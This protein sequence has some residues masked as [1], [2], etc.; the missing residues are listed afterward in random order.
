MREPGE[1]RLT[2]YKA[3]LSRKEQCLRGLLTTGRTKSLEWTRQGGTRVRAW[4]RAGSVRVR[5]WGNTGRAATR[6][7]VQRGLAFLRRHPAGLKA[8]RIAWMSAAGLLVLAVVC[9]ALWKIPQWQVADP[10]LTVKD[11][12]ELQDKARGTLAQIIG[13]MVILVGLY[14]TGRSAAAAWRNVQVTQE[15]QITERFT[16]A[17]EQLGNDKL[18]IRLGGIYALERIARD[19]PT[20]HWPIM[21]V[22]TAYVRE[23]APWKD[24][25]QSE[26][27]PAADIQAIL[28]VL[29]RR[30]YGQDE[31]Q[32]L[33][34]QDTD[35]RNVNL[36]GAHLEGAILMRAHL[37]D[38]DLWGAHLQG[39]NLLGAH[40]KKANLMDAHLTRAVLVGAH[41]E[42]AHLER[43]HLE[44]ARLR[45][46]HLTRA[47]L[48]DAH[49][50]GAYLRQSFLVDTFQRSVIGITKEQLAS[51]ILDESTLLPDYLT[52]EEACGNTPTASGE[53]P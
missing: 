38:A 25:P 19:S 23:H 52:T 4:G 39:A 37:E 12:L 28:T 17:I 43:A 21:E 24:T 13:G 5:H 10:T 45:G 50:E 6:N 29:G 3:A 34:L 47:V 1:K 48:V 9:L 36:L 53:A 7:R 42:E 27:K 22:L 51:A 32:R 8:I 15:G 35:L 20:D 49:L 16:R 18:A 40:L 41:L 46:A 26:P 31:K 30:R 44:D 14:F 33:D 2:R 11:R